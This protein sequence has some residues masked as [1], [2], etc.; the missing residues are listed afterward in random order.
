M[1]GPLPWVRDYTAAKLHMEPL[2]LLTRMAGREEEDRRQGGREEEV[3]GR[4]DWKE[5]IQRKEDGIEGKG[6]R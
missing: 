3:G 2:T 4:K 5:L 6:R 1:C